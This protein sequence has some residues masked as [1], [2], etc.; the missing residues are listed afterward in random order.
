MDTS[1]VPQTMMT[2]TQDSFI[3][4]PSSIMQVEPVSFRS[5]QPPRPK[6][7]SLLNRFSRSM[8]ESLADIAENHPGVLQSM[9]NQRPMTPISNMPMLTG[10]RRP[11]SALDNAEFID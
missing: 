10:S 6:T 1:G 9:A 3:P 8:V 4:P 11:A 5:V 2:D 7:P